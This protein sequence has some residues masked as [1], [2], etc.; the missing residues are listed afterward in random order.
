MG[1]GMKGILTELSGKD[2]SGID[3]KNSC[4]VPGRRNDLFQ[5]R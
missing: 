2:I 5:Q 3:E 4:Q 1:G